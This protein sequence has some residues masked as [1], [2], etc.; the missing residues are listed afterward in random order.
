MKI[1]IYGSSEYQRHTEEIAQMVVDL[2]SCGHTLCAETA[3]GTHLRQAGCEVAICGEEDDSDLMLSIGGDGTMLRAARRAVAMGVPLLGVNAGHL[4]YLTSTDLAGAPE[5]VDIFAK[6]KSKIEERHLLR[7]SIADGPC[8]LA[9]NEVALLRHDT[10]KMLEMRTA[11]NGDYLT[12]YKG[13]GLIISTPTGSTAYNLS[14]GGPLLDPTAA[15]VILTPLSPHSLN[16]RPLVI[17]NDSAIS[18]TTETRADT[19]QVSVDGSTVV[20]PRGTSIVVSE[21]PTTLQLVQLP[22]HNFAETLRRKLLWGE[23]AE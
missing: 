19:F 16:M 11:I 21:A 8:Q 12:T 13:D 4:G 6:G 17:P 22:S 20:C 18:V 7:V 15:C 5:A 3:F 23:T 1:V 9:L 2:E 10:S 14:A